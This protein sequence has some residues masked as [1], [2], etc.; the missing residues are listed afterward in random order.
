MLTL[1]GVGL[2]RAGC[3]LWVPYY[4]SSFFFETKE[5]LKR[6]RVDKEGD[7][8]LDREAHHK[9]TGGTQF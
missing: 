3:S 4:S 8:V 9:L 6:T 2:Q 1:G 5:I 7:I